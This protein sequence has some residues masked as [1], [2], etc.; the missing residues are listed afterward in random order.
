M[1][2]P[3]MLYRCWGKYSLLGKKDSTVLMLIHN[4]NKFIYDM[5]HMLL[6]THGTYFLSRMCKI[7]RILKIM[8]G[9]FPYIAGGKKTRIPKKNDS[10]LKPFPGP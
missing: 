7:C 3:E 4:L 2:L 6:Y 9:D 8:T 1:S 5:F 10:R